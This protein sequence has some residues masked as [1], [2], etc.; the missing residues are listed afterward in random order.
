MNYVKAV[1]V[2][3]AKKKCITPTGIA[4]YPHL[5]KAHSFQGGAPKFSLE[6]RFSKKDDLSPLKKAAHW[7]AVERWGEDKANWPKR[8]RSP[9]KDG[10]EKA[11]EKPEYEGL[12]YI[13]ASS[14]TQPG[15]VERDGVTEIITADKLYAGCYARAELIAFA[16]DTAGNVGIGFALL[17]VQKI[18][19]G[20]ALG[21]KR[22]ARE[23]FE[24]VEVEDDEWGGGEE[25]EV[26]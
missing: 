12:I 16:Y 17:N 26:F 2:D 5:F 8:L 24:A 11:D 25:D 1:E 23:V 6:L 3:I 15:I 7:A 21:G 22:K 9:F 14:K 4:S 19:D 20:E 18:K 13:R 10:D